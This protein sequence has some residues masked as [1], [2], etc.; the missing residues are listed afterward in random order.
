[1]PE[2]GTGNQPWEQAWQQALYG[3]A[4]FYRRPEGPAGHFRTAAHASAGGLLGAALA[5][6]A[7]QAGCAAVLDVGAGRGELIT[8]VAAADPELTCTGVDVVARPDRL[9]A[10]I[11]WGR[12]V[13]TPRVPT[14][15]VGWELLDVVPAPVLEV[16]AAGGLR[17]VEVDGAG[18]ERLAGP[19][20]PEDVAWCERWWPA[21][22]PGERVEVG[23]PRDEAWAA[24]VDRLPAA[25]G[26]ALAV[27]YGHLRGRRPAA[28]SL[29]GYRAGLRVDPVPD[30]SCD[31]TSD[32]ALDAVAAA[33]PAGLLVR[34][35]D[36]LAGLGVR[37]ARPPLSAAAG[38]PQGYLRA[39]AAAGEAAELL[40]PGGLGGFGWVLHPVGE[41]AG[42][43]LRALATKW[44]SAAPA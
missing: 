28:G 9:P 18:R 19:A 31:L 22:S 41:P 30:G 17:V 11:G 21:G 7:R 42:G 1:M 23:R 20:S 39:L 10:E 29:R 5:R 15:L 8:A 3:P 43:T 16:D 35:A 27:D 25:G 33:R 36:A 6:L 34:Q 40:D 4:G 38:D 32:V 13:P 2:P 12:E 14:L 44:T 26:L 24:L 37:P